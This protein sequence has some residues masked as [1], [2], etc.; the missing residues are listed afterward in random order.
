MM[1]Y[2]PQIVQVVPHEDYT[3]TVYFCDGNKPEWKAF[4]GDLVIIAREC[5]MIARA[6]FLCFFTLKRQ[7]KHDMVTSERRRI[8]VT[9]N[10]RI[11]LLRQ[12]L[13]LS[14]RAFAERICR[15]TAYINRIEN[16]KAELTEAVIQSIS[17]A[18]GV[19]IS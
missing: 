11:V 17:A 3:A 2:T 19:P 7:A 9:I 6:V 8:V 4:C 1:D 15:S 16:G 12:R 18:F 10:G 13:G 14:Q 5:R